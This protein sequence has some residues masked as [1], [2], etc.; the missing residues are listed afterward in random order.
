MYASKTIPPLERYRKVCKKFPP[1]FYRWFIK[2]FPEPSAWFSARL[3]F[4]R[5]AA[6]MSMV[7]HIVGLGDRHGENILLDELSGEVVHIDLN[8]LFWKGLTFDEPELVPFRLTPHMT[9]ALGITKYEGVFRRCCEVTLGVLRGN[10]DTLMS[11]LQ[12]LLDDPLVEAA[13]K[14]GRPKNDFIQAINA[15]NKLLKGKFG[16]LPLSVEGHVHKLLEEATD[17]NNLSKVTKR[18]EFCVHY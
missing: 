10:R 16:L 3:A 6:V 15:I 1:I 17:E 4:S 8:C 2:E 7:G 12:P 13:H 9:D 5:T 18:K 14:D 11:V